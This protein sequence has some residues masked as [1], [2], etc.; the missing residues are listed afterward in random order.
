MFGC[1][2]TSSSTAT[3]CSGPYE[4]SRRFETAPEG[5]LVFAQPPTHISCLYTH[6]YAC[7][8]KC[9]CISVYAHAHTHVH[10]QCPKTHVLVRDALAIWYALHYFDRVEHVEVHRLHQ[11]IDRM[12]DGMLDG[13]FDGM[14]ERSMACWME[15]SIR[16][17]T[18]RNM[19]HGL[20]PGQCPH[21][22]HV[23]QWRTEW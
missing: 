18:N 3:A 14:M 15:C 1:L 2:Q 22:R 23:K 7:V 5:L 9:L 13:M 6:R 12:F 21:C 4:V 19:F 10:A 8:Y 16:D 11:H 20:R 17:S